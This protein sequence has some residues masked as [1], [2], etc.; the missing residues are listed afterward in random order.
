MYHNVQYVIRILQIYSLLYFL[1]H[2]WIFSLFISSNTLYNFVQN[3]IAQIF[4]LKTMLLFWN[5]TFQR[6]HK[7]SS[8]CTFFSYITESLDDIS[9]IYPVKYI[10]YRPPACHIK[11]S[12]NIQKW[13]RLK[14][15]SLVSTQNNITLCFL[16][17]CQ[18][19]G[20]LFGTPFFS[21]VFHLLLHTTLLLNLFHSLLPTTIL[22]N[23]F[24]LQFYLIH[25]KWKRSRKSQKHSLTSTTES[26]S[27]LPSGFEKRI[28]Q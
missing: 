14:N 28:F 23:L 13:C 10:M 3:F 9:H 4:V 15:W 18:Q 6:I 2:Y 26:W 1:L 8:S 7:R 17:C 12:N 11:I 16:L 25:Q 24:H 5:K 21:D 22:L 20:I 27:N 19:P